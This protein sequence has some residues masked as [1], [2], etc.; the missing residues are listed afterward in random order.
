M[1][2]AIYKNK[3]YLANVR[4]S[5]I[6]LKTRIN[7]LV[8]LAGNVHK[9]IFIKEVDINNVEIIYEVDYRVLYKGN[10]YKC[11]KVAKE[12]LDINY[13]TI[14]TSDSDIAAK[15]EFIKKEQFIFDKDVSLDE[16]DALIEI[17]KP[18]LK[19]NCLKEQRTKIEQKDIKDYLSKI[20]E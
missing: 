5:K 6:R 16:I 10:E 8:D 11:L 9:D 3:V 18:I 14:Y 19:F 4:E 7:E 1:I 17:K 15:Y 12:T 13:I 2:Y 20:I